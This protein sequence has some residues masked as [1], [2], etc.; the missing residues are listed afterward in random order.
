MSGVPLETCWAFNE[1]WNNKFCYKVASCWLFLLNH[2]TLHRFINIKKMVYMLTDVKFFPF[3]C[4]KMCCLITLSTQP[5]MWSLFY[6]TTIICHFLPLLWHMC[7][8]GC[9]K[10]N[11]ITGLDRYWGF[12]EVQAPRF[13]DNR[14]MV[15][16][17]SALCTGYLYAP[18][19]I[20]CT[21]F[22]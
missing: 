13:Q 19:N 22:C 12:Q 10:S 5:Y 9:V 15:V 1:R 17:L 6:M 21:H 11:P 14:H 16:R 18:G 20:P 4:S 8:L 3:Q 7:V 2:T